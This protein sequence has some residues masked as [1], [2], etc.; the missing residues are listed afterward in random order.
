MNDEA[1]RENEARREFTERSKLPELA[2]F[3]R[4]ITLQEFVPVLALYLSEAAFRCSNIKN[5]QNNKAE[6]SEDAI[7]L[8]QFELRRVLSGLKDPQPDINFPRYHNYEMELCDVIF[9][10]L[11]FAEDKR[12][13][14]GNAFA[15]KVMFTLELLNKEQ[16]EQRPANS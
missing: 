2:G 7:S 3:L 10:I 15:E 16:Y 11:S 9:G 14:I 4:H 12:I 1:R 6:T 5:E 8:L 13:P